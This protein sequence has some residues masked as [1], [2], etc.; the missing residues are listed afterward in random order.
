MRQGAAGGGRGRHRVGLRHVQGPPAMPDVAALAQLAGDGVARGAHGD[1]G[2]RDIA[3]R[4]IEAQRL[5]ELEIFGR[6]R[7]V[8]PLLEPVDRVA[9]DNKL[10]KIGHCAI[11][12]AAILSGRRLVEASA[13]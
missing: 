4:L 2:Q 11:P 5:V 9:I 1:V 7:A 10:K 8:V 6:K 12:F 3:G 13:W